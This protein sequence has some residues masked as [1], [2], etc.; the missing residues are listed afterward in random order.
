MSDTL[1]LDQ[2]DQHY[3]TID[4]DF[5]GIDDD[6]L[7]IVPE[8]EGLPVLDASLCPPPPDLEH[9]DDVVEGLGAGI[10]DYVRPWRE[11][12]KF[13]LA[14]VTSGATTPVGMCLQNVRLYF[15]VAALYA[16]A[17]LSL[18]GAQALGKAYQVAFD[19]VDRIPRGS[20]VYFI[21]P[22]S[23]YGHI[24][25]SL[26]GGW[27]ISTDW[28]RGRFG[29][30]RIDDLARAWGYTEIFWSP[31]VN[32]VRVWAPSRPVPVQLPRVPGV[33]VVDGKAHGRVKP[34]RHAASSKVREDGDRVYARAAVKHEGVVWFQARSGLWYRRQDL[35]YLRPSQIKTE[36]KD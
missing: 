2:L 3:A 35:A 27:C 20:I 5:E 10:P 9:Q 22:N 17:K 36:K 11:A 34:S 23:Q 33:F 24:V 30:V 31:L 4:D 21:G 16:C 1:E 8:A 18:A 12:I 32:D 29:R 6:D 14:K 28:P 15:L 26:G 7:K 13:A 25:I 19:A